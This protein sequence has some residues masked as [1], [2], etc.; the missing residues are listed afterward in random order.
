MPL[1]N[2][3]KHPPLSFIFNVSGDRSTFFSISGKAKKV[4]KSKKKASKPKKEKNPEPAEPEDSPNSEHDEEPVHK[5]L[6]SSEERAANKIATNI[7]KWRERLDALLEGDD[8]EDEEAVTA[9]LEKINR[10]QRALE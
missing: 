10:N 7:V 4:K 9:L 6:G 3:L 2:T 5:P 8:S 1:L